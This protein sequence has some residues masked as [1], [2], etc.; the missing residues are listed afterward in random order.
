MNMRMT[1]IMPGVFLALMASVHAKAQSIGPS[2]IDAAGGTAGLAGNT[3]EWS[4][5]DMAVITTYTSGSL[6]VTQ[7]TLQPFNIPV[8]VNKITLDQ[9]LKAYPNPATSTVYLEYNLGNSGKLEYMLQDIAGKTVFQKTI[10]VTPGGGKE[11]ISMMALA[12]AAYVL[13][14]TYR[15]NEGS[16]QTVTFKVIKSANN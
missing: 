6:V 1:L 8:G 11:A 7:G 9:Q 5:G 15:P 2:T 14:V 16:P 13:N 3:Y 4:V 12:N 10:E